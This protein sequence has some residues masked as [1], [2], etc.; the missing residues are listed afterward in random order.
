M[1]RLLELDPATARPSLELWHSL[2][3]PEE[4]GSLQR[5]FAESL[6]SDRRFVIGH[7]LLFPNGRTK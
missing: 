6:A 2:V 5:R 1:Y 7:R 4:Q 3:V